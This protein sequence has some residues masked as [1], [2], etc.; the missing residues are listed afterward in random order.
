MCNSPLSAPARKET[1]HV[2]LTCSERKTQA[3]APELRAGNLVP[4]SLRER[5][6][7]WTTALGAS[8]TATKTAENLYK[9]DH[10]QIARSIAR[11]AGDVANVNVWVASAGYG[12]VQLQT[13]MHA[14]A[15]TFS[16]RHAD[17]VVP[18]QAD[19]SA[20]D[21]WRE[22][23][24][25]QPPDLTGPRTLER[26]ADLVAGRPG[27]FLLVALSE[28]YASALRADIA[29]AAGILP[30]RIGLLSIGTK[31]DPQQRKSSALADYL[32]PTDHRLKGVVG[33]AMQSLNARVARQ[34]VVHAAEWY[35]STQRLTA[36]TN[37]WLAAA[38]TPVA[39]DRTRLSDEDV[40][41]FI[42]RALGRN[43]STAH[44]VALRALRESG[45]ACEQARFATLYK[46]VKA[47]VSND[48]THS[49]KQVSSD[50]TL[51]SDTSSAVAN[52]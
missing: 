32:I 12:L 30:D 48:M 41:G 22:L 18:A 20:A 3:V 26:L 19:F 52:R 7:A 50:T 15:A 8:Q 49:R 39:L 40:K 23:A 21:W 29:A 42:Q 33:G 9:G 17:S 5:L 28:T 1:L 11:T 46:E 47:T 44:T 43:P 45:Q 27:D 4:A 2:V 16:R 34:I 24:L 51:Q 13:P 14:Y 10:W 36:L 6:Q 25:W 31:G 38:S 37:G 35:P